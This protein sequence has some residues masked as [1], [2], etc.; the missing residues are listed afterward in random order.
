MEQA[1]SFQNVAITPTSKANGDSSGLYIFTI[2]FSSIVNMNEYLKITPP[3]AVTILP[4]NDQ[5][6]GLRNLS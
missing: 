6:M 2:V 1:R 4:D 3:P 5:C